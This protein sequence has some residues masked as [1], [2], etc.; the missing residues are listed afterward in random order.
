MR[1][2]TA[3]AIALAVA[4]M[5]TFATV[6]AATKPAPPPAK[7]PVE[8]QP[9]VAPAPT[10]TLERIKAAGKIVLA[11][12]ADATAMSSRDGSGQ[13]TGFSVTLCN[14]VADA[15]KRDLA[16]PT[17]SVE[18]V[19]AAPGFADL[20]SHH[21]DLICDADEVT[22]T[23]R[24]KASFSIPIF[25]GGVSA[26]VRADAAASLQQ[27]LEQRPQ[28]YKPL[29]RGTPPPTLENR[30]YS[31]LGGS[32]TMDALIAH[33]AN[34]RLIANVEPV[35]NY[36]AGVAAV[37]NGRTSVLF[38]DRAQLLQAALSSPAAKNLRVLSRRFTFAAIGLA[39]ARNDDDFRLAVDRGLTNIFADPQFGA[40]Y[41]ATFGTP[42]ADTVAFFRSVAVAK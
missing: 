30:T 35:A 36:E 1:N 25:P 14:R 18:W 17:L 34:M 6:N 2:S 9:V 8:E 26:L 31:A 5:A 23:N 24:A 40:L 13:P 37:A 32:S 3:V 7:P 20:E 16:L 21:V 15:L 41:G 39:L 10:T 12:R 38:G 27:A 4:A 33:I 28:P 11:Y 42:D 19:A 22:L 29:W